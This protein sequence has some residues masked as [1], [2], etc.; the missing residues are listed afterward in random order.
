[1]INARMI[2]QLPVLVALLLTTPGAAEADTPLTYDRVSLAYTASRDVENDTLV[3]ILFAQ[4]EG[5]ETTRLADEVNR[6]ITR[7]IERAKQVQGVKVQTLDYHTSPVYQ[8]QSVV[9]WRVQQSLRLESRDAAQL[10]NLV[11]ELQKELAVQSIGYAVSPE[12]RTAAE[13]ALIGEAV[14]GFEKRAALVAGRLGRPSYRLVDLSVEAGGEVS[15]RPMMMRGA[16]MAMMAEA[17]PPAL[18][19]GTRTIEVTVRGTVELQRP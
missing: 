12:Q 5:G 7:A 1:M 2:A 4:R 9:G 8:Q 14:A 13:E 18:E 19:A 11:G 16:P 17:A 3:A 10:G 6:A 15:P